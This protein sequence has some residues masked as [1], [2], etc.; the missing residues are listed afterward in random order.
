MF[1]LCPLYHVLFVV[2]VTSKVLNSYAYT[3]YF[4]RLPYSRIV[5]LIALKLKRS[6]NLN[7][8]DRDFQIIFC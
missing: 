5:Y 4:K 8:G 1:V 2:K 6:E 3:P 7:M